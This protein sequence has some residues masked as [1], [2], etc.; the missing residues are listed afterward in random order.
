MIPDFKTYIKESLWS[1]IQDRNSGEVMRKEDQL[2]KDDEEYLLNWL[3]WFATRIV[4]VKD[5]DETYDDFCNYVNNVLVKPNKHKNKDKVLKVAKVQWENVWS[6]KLD[7][8]ITKENEHLNESIWSDIQDRNSGE[9]IR[10]E[11]IVKINSFDRDKMYDYIEKNYKIIASNAKLTKIGYGFF[12]SLYIPLFKVL[13]DVNVLRVQY[14]K[15]LQSSHDGLHEINL[16][17]VNKTDTLDLIEKLSQHFDIYYDHM[18]EVYHI[19]DK[20]LNISNMLLLEVIDFIIGYVQNPILKKKVNESLWSDIQDRNSGEVIRKEDEIDNSLDFGDLFV[21]IK[22]HYEELDKSNKYKIGQFRMLGDLA[23]IGCISLPIEKRP[24]P[25]LITL[26]GNLEKDV[27]YSA[28]LKE[29]FLQYYPDLKKYL[30]NEYVFDDARMTITP[31]N[32]EMTNRDCINIL[33][34]ILAM[35]EHPLL[36]R[37]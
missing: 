33:D 3:A 17:I 12:Q 19:K 31:A 27:L 4:Y 22:D 29:A 21:Y 37:K 24:H 13:E 16:K 1:D 30:G 23:I 10:K 2:T 35:V 36:R 11:D 7:E 14:T 6:K 28:R 26:R 15:G 9:V 8:M 32:R 34:R 5:Y 25:L 18:L 20:E